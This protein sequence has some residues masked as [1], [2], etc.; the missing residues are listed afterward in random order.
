MAHEVNNIRDELL[1]D[2]RN[3]QYCSDDT[4]QRSSKYKLLKNLFAL[5]TVSMLVVVTVQYT[6]NSGAFV[7]RVQ[8]DD[9]PFFQPL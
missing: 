3:A 1:S 9:D 5:A 2:L 7:R 6:T 8:K 4:S